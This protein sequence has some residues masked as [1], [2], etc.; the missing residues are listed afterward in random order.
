MNKKFSIALSDR[1]ERNMNPNL[2]Y[3]V[4]PFEVEMRYAY[5]KHNSPMQAD[6][7]IM[8]ENILH[9]G[10]CLPKACSNNQ[11][12]LLLRSHLGDIISQ[13]EIGI[14]PEVLEVKNLKLNPRFFFKSSVW[15]LIACVIF[16]LLLS[17]LAATLEKAMKL[18]EN[19]NIALGMENK[20]KL[21]FSDEIIKCFNYVQNK[22]AIQSKEPSKGAVN[23][24][25]G[26]R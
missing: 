1:F 17:R 9:I 10:L 12:K 15:I 4:S 8:V 23:S 2:L 13:Q 11:I 21:R 19:N 18:D 16:T 24:I 20:V 7:K 26:L 25:S 5:V 22:K 6:F 3:D 14:Q